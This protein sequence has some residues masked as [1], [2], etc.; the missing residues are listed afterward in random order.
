MKER[1][2]RAAAKLRALERRFTGERVASLSYEEALDLFESM[3]REAQ[4][5]NPDFPGD[6]RESVA[7]RIEIARVLNAL[8]DRK[9]TSED[10]PPVAAGRAQETPGAVVRDDESEG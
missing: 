4:A 6:W 3:W 2:E 7:S 5:L 9:P 1:A 10:D 8:G